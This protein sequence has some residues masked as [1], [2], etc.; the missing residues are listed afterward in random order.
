M[1][2]FRVKLN[3]SK[4]GTM[5]VNPATQSQ[6]STSV[7]RTI[8]VQGPGRK[9]RKLFDGE[10]FV[11]C[12]YWKQFAYPQVGEDQAFIEVISD[13]GSIYSEN[14][15]ENNFPSVYTLTV[16]PSSAYEDN[17][18][19]IAGDTG[20]FSNFVQITNFGDNQINIKLNGLDSAIFVLGQQE[21]QVFNSGDLLVTKLEFT[22][23]ISGAV[24]ADVQVLCS[25]R[26]L[27][28][29]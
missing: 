11:D 15:A 12:N 5:D 22:N 18:I 23:T 13:D 7:Q 19:D 17:V 10:E 6:F 1:S 21:T 16:S 14:P 9:Y 29:S 4:Q 27:C 26:R 8:F 2:E 24:D 3:N 20:A 25:V 28:L